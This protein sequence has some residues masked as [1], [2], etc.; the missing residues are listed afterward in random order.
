MLMIPAREALFLL[1]SSNRRQQIARKFA[2]NCQILQAKFRCLDLWTGL[3]SRLHQH[4][5]AITVVPFDREFAARLSQ[6]LQ[7]FG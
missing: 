3:N 1:K 4:D 6:C 2:Q 7:R 5:A